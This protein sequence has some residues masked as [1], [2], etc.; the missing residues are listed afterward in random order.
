MHQPHHGGAPPSSSANLSVQ[1]QI[2]ALRA[3]IGAQD[4]AL[5]QQQQPSP[6]GRP[7]FQQ[8]YS[9]SSAGHDS[10]P[11]YMNN[12]SSSS[13][14]TYADPARAA[15]TRTIKP[16][17]HL[18]QQQQQQQN[19]LSP[20]T[21]TTPRP[22]SVP[23]LT[24]YGSSNLS[25]NAG[26]SSRFAA[27]AA[28]RPPARF[29]LSEST[30]PVLPMSRI[31]ETR[32]QAM[33]TTLPA[34]MRLGTS[35]LMQP[36]VDHEALNAANAASV[37]A[38][39]LGGGG[40]PGYG[41]ADGSGP[42]SGAM[43]PSG[44][45]VAMTGGT[46][47][48]GRRTRTTV[49]YAELEA[50]NFHVDEDPPPLG[51]SNA[52][53][54]SRR[55]STVPAQGYS[56]GTPGPV[57]GAQ[58]EPEAKQVWGDGK[59]Y[60]G[61]MPPGNL[62]T[63]Q[64][65]GKT[66]HAYFSEDQLEAQAKKPAV[67]VPIEIDLDV[68]GFKIRDAFVWNAREELVSI[69]DFAKIMCEDLDIAQTNAPDIASQISEQ[70]AEWSHAAEL[71]VRSNE[72]E[73]EHAGRDL[74]VMLPLDVQ[75]GT[76]HLVDRIEWDLTSSLTPEAFAQS[77]AHDLSLPMHAIPTIAHALHYEI[78]RAKRI[79]EPTGVLAP[80]KLTDNPLVDMQQLLKRRAGPKALEGVWRE[81]ND[82]GPCG[83][84][85]ELLSF[86]EVEKV[87]VSKDKERK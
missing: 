72:E 17:R 28:R 31:S 38:A 50:L 63:V 55:D 43:T 73:R 56:N 49:N 16:P 54:R 29:Q 26:A 57:A 87:L 24:N 1:Q 78:L 25:A 83:P 13:A 62:L 11:A 74:R 82:A 23:P 37:A 30:A 33:Y 27:L 12:N 20:S 51:T 52:N 45:G 47:T 69:M 15:S 53:Q 8:H 67:L 85:I 75:I 19:T 14:S 3:Q 44:T 80:L 64:L 6:G 79:L 58:P 39:S 48:T 21:S 40:T 60:L 22:V 41:G 66:K 42:A 18:L 84:K 9:A 77:L 2:A 86:E 76:L 65:R 32:Y 36:V 5:Q 4:S 68:D 10:F 35:L 59:S 34:R 7:S 61:Q 71:P 81:W 70:V 46:T